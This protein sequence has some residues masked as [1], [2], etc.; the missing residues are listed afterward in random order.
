MGG[1]VNKQLALR[2][3]V[4]RYMPYL[5]TREFATIGVVAT[6]PKTGYFDYKM[7][8]RFGRFSRFF[9]E[10]DAKTY[11]AAVNYFSKELEE[12]K[13]I[14]NQEYLSADFLRSLF[15]QITRDR[16][17]IIY[18]SKPKVRLVANEEQGLDYLFEHYVNH[19]FVTTENAQEILTRRVADLVKGLN[20]R[21]PF[22]KLKLDGGLFHATFP[23]VQVDDTNHPRKIIKPLSLQHDDPNTMYESADVWVGR[24]NRLKQVKQ[25]TDKTSVLFAYE[26]PEK[27]TTQQAEAF[28]MILERMS[29]SNIESTEAKEEKYILEFVKA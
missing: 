24:V 28:Q 11:K 25:I 4:I 10:F 27:M 20:L 29:Q 16:E 1:Q 3:A 5:E 23:L 6:C 13:K 26:K 17:A 9:P 14:A 7:A 12:I 19:S 21:K 2:Y 18:T 15:A 8:S 22:K